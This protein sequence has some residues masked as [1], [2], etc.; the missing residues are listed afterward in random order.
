MRFIICAI[1]KNEAHILEEWIRHYLNRGV[2]HIYLVN[3]DS[4]DDYSSVVAKFTEKVSVFDNDVFSFDLGSRRMYIYN[5]YFKPLLQ[6]ADWAAFLDLSD[7]LYNPDTS[8]L[9]DVISSYTNYSQIMADCLLFGSNRLVDIP[10]SAVVSSFLRREAVASGKRSIFKCGDLT[11]FRAI[12][13]VVKGE[14]TTEVADL[15]V[16]NYCVQSVQWFLKVKAL[17]GSLDCKDLNIDVAYFK[18]R[19]LNAVTDNR[20]FMQSKIISK[21]SRPL[22]VFAPLADDWA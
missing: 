4:T 3:D 19:D 21:V 8:F 5:K 11:E 18:E 12:E 22:L 16:N 6:G 2:S 14:T 20:L 10:T 7:F 15:L 9:P 17:R 13:H 1:F